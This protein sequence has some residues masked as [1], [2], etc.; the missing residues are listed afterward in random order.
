[1]LTRREPNEQQATAFAADLVASRPRDHADLDL[2]V[3]DPASLC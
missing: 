3:P 2:A 1:M